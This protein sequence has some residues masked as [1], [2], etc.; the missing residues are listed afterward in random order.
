MVTPRIG[1]R[2]E[3][4]HV[5]EGGRQLNKPQTKLVENMSEAVLP[6]GSS[7]ESAFVCILTCNRLKGVQSKLM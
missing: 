7:G 1:Q 2:G 3:D 5:A 6:V 4:N